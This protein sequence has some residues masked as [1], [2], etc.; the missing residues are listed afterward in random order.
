MITPLFRRLCAAALCT[1]AAD[2]AQAQTGRPLPTRAMD[3][4]CG[5]VP[6]SVRPP[7]PGQIAE[8]GQL[9][10]RLVAIG[11]RNG[12]SAPTGLLMVDVDSTYKGT[13][14]FM[15]SNYPEPA[16]RQTTRAVSEYLSSLPRG[17]R[18]Q[19]L[20]RVD[21]EY[22]AVAP[23]RQHCRPV[24]KN[25]E[26]QQEEMARVW[27][28]HPERGK[29]AAAVDRQVVLLLV[30]SRDG[31]VTYSGIARPSGD[32]YLDEAAPSVG[33]VLKFEP[34]TLDGIPFDARYRLPLNFSIR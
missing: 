26:D 9:R 3:Q 19:A 25:W 17:R 23:G 11:R 4:Q 10:E 13:V 1:L 29:L 20:I 12:V 34:A 21:G 5:V 28:G 6:D 16:V 18:Y 31:T 33:R 7:T 8:R 15:Q 24:L 2:A 22:P 30:V 27:R 32:P 14:L